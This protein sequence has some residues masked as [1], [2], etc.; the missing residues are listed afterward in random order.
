MDIE[1]DFKEL[2][3]DDM[4]EDPPTEERIE[5]E[6]ATF[7]EPAL[8]APKHVS[9]ISVFERLQAGIIYGSKPLK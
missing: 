1:D 6:A 4:E 8:P 3:A 5:T 2:H 7:A 9:P